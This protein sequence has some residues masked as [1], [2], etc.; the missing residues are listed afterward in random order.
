[1]G[2]EYR[3]QKGATTLLE[4]VSDTVATISLDILYNLADSAGV[5]DKPQLNFEFNRNISVNMK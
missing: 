1:M 5:R 3:T 2:F 4:N